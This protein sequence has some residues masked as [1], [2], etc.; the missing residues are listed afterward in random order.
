LKEAKMDKQEAIAILLLEAKAYQMHAQKHWERAQNYLDMYLND[1]M[2]N[3]MWYENEME[4]YLAFSKHSRVLLAA[5][6]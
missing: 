3:L 6:L 4:L 1:C 5:C 2:G